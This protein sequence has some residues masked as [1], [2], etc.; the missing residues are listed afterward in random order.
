MPSAP[1]AGE[2]WLEGWPPGSCPNC[3]LA[4]PGQPRGGACGSSAQQTAPAVPQSSSCLCEM[5]HFAGT[6]F[7]AL[8]GFGGA[9]PGP[10]GRRSGER[11]SP[12][13]GHSPVPADGPEL[14]AGSRQRQSLSVPARARRAV[15]AEGASLVA[16]VVLRTGMS[17]RAPPGPPPA[18]TA[19]SDCFAS[20][21]TRF[22]R[23]P[24]YILPVSSTCLWS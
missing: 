13:L 7:Q 12:A 6:L 24:L 11:R 17:G 19:R 22:P 23:R 16:A 3:R 15:P 4:A 9:L 14:P 20:S 8:R 5:G 10:L 21:E 2:G 1:L 18:N